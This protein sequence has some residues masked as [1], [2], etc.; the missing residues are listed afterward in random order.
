MTTTQTAVLV[1]GAE[2]NVYAYL[3]TNDD[4]SGVRDKVEDL[5][6]ETIGTCRVVSMR[7]LRNHQA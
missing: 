1:Q 2:G 3:T 6:Y 5:G 7:Q 4:I